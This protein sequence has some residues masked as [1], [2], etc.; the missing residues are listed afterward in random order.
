MISFDSANKYV[1]TMSKKF[2]RNIKLAKRRGFDVEMMKPIVHNLANDI[3]LDPRYHDHQ[4]SGGMSRFR[5]C[6]IAPDWLL[7][8]EKTDGALILYLYATGTHADIME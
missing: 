8:Y 2:K 5:E 6:H 3:P 4:L 1:I 7:L